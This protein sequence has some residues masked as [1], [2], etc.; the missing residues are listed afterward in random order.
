MIEIRVYIQGYNFTPRWVLLSPAISLDKNR[1]A[2][3]VPSLVP[4]CPLPYI[5]PRARF[6]LGLVSI[7]LTSAARALVS[8]KQGEKLA[9][10]PPRVPKSAP[11][12]AFRYSF[13]KSSSKLT[14]T[15]RISHPKNFSSKIERWIMMVSR[16]GCTAQR[17]SSFSLDE[18]VNSFELYRAQSFQIVD[19]TS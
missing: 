9:K 19:F 18:W 17:A 10:Y 3:L 12:K 5:K 14:Y 13:V 8:G 4:H 6:L 11:G 7:P 15:G 1:K 2:S 16:F